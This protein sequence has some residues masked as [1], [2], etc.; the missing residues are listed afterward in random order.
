MKMAKGKGSGAKKEGKGSGNAKSK[1]KGKTGGKDD[2]DT[3][4]GTKK[5]FNEVHVSHILW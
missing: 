4:S 3:N 2:K 5:D 1:G